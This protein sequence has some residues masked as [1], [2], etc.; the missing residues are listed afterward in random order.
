MLKFLAQY[1]LDKND[2]IFNNTL[3]GIILRKKLLGNCFF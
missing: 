1:G 2:T 3:S